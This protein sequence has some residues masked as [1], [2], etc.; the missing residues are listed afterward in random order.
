MQSAW[1]S[2]IKMIASK[3]EGLKGLSNLIFSKY[4]FR[5]LTFLVFLNGSKEVP[6]QTVIQ[7]NSVKNDY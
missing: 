2:I 7:I 5:M 3:T 4:D 1:G 6:V